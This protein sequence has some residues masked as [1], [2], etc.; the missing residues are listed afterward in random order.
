MRIHECMHTDN[1][2]WVVYIFAYK[3][4]LYIYYIIMFFIY[5]TTPTYMT[6]Y[7]NKNSYVYPLV[8]KHGLGKS[9]HLLQATANGSPDSEAGAD[10]GRRTWRR[11]PGGLG[12]LEDYSYLIWHMLMGI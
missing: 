5:T 7:I 1:D 3:N 12:V 2:M 10:A 6:I 8:I 9:H 4:Y 11:S